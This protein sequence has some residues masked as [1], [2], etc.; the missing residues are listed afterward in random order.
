MKSF[1][2][3]AILLVAIPPNL[4]QAQVWPQP[5]P[6][7]Q[8]GQGVAPTTNGTNAPVE[9][10]PQSWPYLKVTPSKPLFSL[11][12]AFGL[13]DNFKL[14]GTFRPRIDGITNQFRP[15]P[16]PHDDMMASFF[17]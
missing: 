8:G 11:H 13:P 4:A 15:A 10:W 6:Q 12:D 5:Q 3:S 17:T 16:F 1:F 14:S 2:L 9:A 7:A